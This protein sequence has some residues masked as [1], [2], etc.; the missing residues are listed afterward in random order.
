[1]CSRAQAMMSS[2]VAWP[3]ASWRS[4]ITAFTVSPR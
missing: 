1:M 3:R 4:T 2:G